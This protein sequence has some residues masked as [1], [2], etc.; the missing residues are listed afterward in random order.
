[1]MNQWKQAEYNSAIPRCGGGKNGDGVD[2]VDI[3]DGVE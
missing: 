2:S 3:V 1:M